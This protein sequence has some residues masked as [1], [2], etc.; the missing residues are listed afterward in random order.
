VF[1]LLVAHNDK[2]KGMTIVNSPYGPQLGNV[3]MV[4]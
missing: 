1:G 4:K 3:Y 2:V